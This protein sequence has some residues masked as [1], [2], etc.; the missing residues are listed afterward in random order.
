MAPPWGPRV[1]PPCFS[2]RGHRVDPVRELRPCKPCGQKRTSKQPQRQPRAGREP[3]RVAENASQ[4]ARSQAYQGPLLPSR[5]VLE[6]HDCA[7]G[8]QVVG[9]EPLLSVYCM[10]GAL[11]QELGD[12]APLFIG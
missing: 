6:L 7:C 1:R 2:C 9:M 11:A 4:R 12:L 3:G 10:H 5:G 8:F